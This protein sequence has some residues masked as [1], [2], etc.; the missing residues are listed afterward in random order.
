MSSLFAQTLNATFKDE[1]Y[2]I[3][4]GW[5]NRDDAKLLLVQID[6]LEEMSD[7]FAGLNMIHVSDGIRLQIE[8]FECDLDNAR[9]QALSDAVE[10][11]PGDEDADEI[12][13][14]FEGLA[15]SVSKALEQH[16]RAVK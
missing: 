12:R 15:I 7:S 13:D 14:H 9:A 1:A 5:Y 4:E 10:A 8:E 3:A 6:A 11:W 16:R 2:A